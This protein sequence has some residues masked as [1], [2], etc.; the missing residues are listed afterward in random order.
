MP[1]LRAR[2]L[3]CL[4]GGAVGDALGA[5]VEF[6]SLA[7]IRTTI[8]SEGV[9]DFMPAYGRLGA[10][11]DDT[12]MALFTA[13]GLLRA[14]VRARLRGICDISTVV[15]HAYIRWLITQG[16]K[17]H[18]KIAEA[19][20]GRAAKWPDGWLIQ[21]RE[22][23]SNRAPGNTCVGALRASV[24]YGQPAANDS[25]GCGTIMRVAPVGLYGSAFD[26]FELGV[27]V[28]RLTHGHPSGY[29]AAGYFAQLIACLFD[30]QRLRDAIPSARARLIE[31]GGDA[32]EVTEA[33]DRAV[34]LA[35][36]GLPTPERVES[37]GGGWTAEEALSIALYCALVATGFDD[38]LRLAVN[39]SGDSDSTGSLVGNILGVIG[40]VEV[41]PSR[42]LDALELRKV[43][44]EVAGDLSTMRDGP[45]DADAMSEKYPGW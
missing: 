45:F 29:F 36:A 37:L 41:I 7:E 6:M 25:K 26:P 2:T 17:P 16:T 3:G 44:E 27:E 33:I 11:T 30:G 24:H 43:I 40:G 31:H 23:W 34:E 39:H 4:L 12:Q 9:R 20:E 18:A 42:W 32:T 35:D 14:N 28:S 5:P 15:H 13:E 10:I 22:L 19:H 1:A 21:Q 8:G 38:G